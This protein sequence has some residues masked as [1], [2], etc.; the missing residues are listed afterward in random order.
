MDQIS[1]RDG[2]Y[3]KAER[4]GL[5]LTTTCVGIYDPSTAPDGR[6]RFKDILQAFEN[7][8]P[9]NPIFRSKLVQVPLDL[10]HPYW[11]DDPDFDIEFH[12]RHIALPEPGDWRQ[13]YIQLARLQSRP[14]DSNHPLWEAYVIEGLHNLT[15]IP[16]GSF[17]IMLKVHRAAMNGMQAME[18]M[19]ALHDL[20]PAKPVRKNRYAAFTPRQLPSPLSLVGQSLSNQVQRSSD[21]IRKIPAGIATY[22]KVS[23]PIAEY[24]S[25]R[26]DTLRTRFNQSISPYRTFGCESFENEHINLLAESEN[27]TPAAVMLTIIAGALRAYLKVNSELPDT[28]LYCLFD[29]Y[30]DTSS[31]LSLATEIESPVE[32]LRATAKHLEIASSQ[33]KVRQQAEQLAVDSVSPL[34]PLLTSI[35]VKTGLAKNAL[36]TLMPQHNT[37]VQMINSVNVPIFFAGAALKDMFV[38]GP[39]QEESGLYHAVTQVYGRTNIAVTAC[40]KSMSDPAFYARCLKEAFNELAEEANIIF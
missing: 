24:R 8:M 12:V 38:L 22:R 19:T 34:P 23:G 14:I 7:G 26:P 36:R 39:L 16:K 20:S 4:P 37:V 9:R 11:M 33:I 18:L 40:R 3:L 28:N 2:L 17:C 6:V 32:R 10:D 30:I 1:A 15:H 29:D 31:M 13:L 5:P 27:T 35:G 25:S 21:A